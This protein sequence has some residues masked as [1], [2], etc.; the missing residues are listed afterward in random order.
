[1]KLSDVFA[2][3]WPEEDDI[4]ALALYMHDLAY[5]LEDRLVETQAPLDDFPDRP[6]AYWTN[7]AGSVPIAGSATAN[8]ALT[9]TWDT[10]PP[11]LFQGDNPTPADTTGPRCPSNRTGL[12]LVGA[13]APLYL[14]TTPNVETFRSISIDAR[15]LTRS[16]FLKSYTGPRFETNL[17]AV[18]AGADSTGA[19]V[20]KAQEANAL[21]PGQVITVCTT[22]WV[23][24]DAFFMESVQSYFQLRCQLRA[25]GNT[26]S[27]I[28]VGAG[29]VYAWAVWL[30]SGE[31]TI[32]QV[33]G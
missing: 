14:A 22:A 1:M 13:S 10:T 30:G 33:G 5:L 2:L 4:G 3:P 19:A 11:I 9:V 7:I 8:S 26:S 12:W 21:T 29:T 25:T 16:G 17:P 32:N 31:E 24:P 20:S 6:A 18:G 28:A 27:A 23:P 15:G